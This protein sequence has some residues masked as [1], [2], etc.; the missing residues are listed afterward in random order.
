MF[1]TLRWL[2][3]THKFEIF[4]LLALVSICQLVWQSL[5]ALQAALSVLQHLAKVQGYHVPHPL[6]IHP[7]AMVVTIHGAG[8]AAL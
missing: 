2:I 5:A 4:C 7:F 3:M 1:A 8:T 6:W